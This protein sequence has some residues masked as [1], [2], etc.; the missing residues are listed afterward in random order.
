MIYILGVAHRA[1]SRKPG[2]QKTEAQQFFEFCLRRTVLEVRPA[3]IGEEDNED[4]LADRGEISIAEEIAVELG[5][6]HRFCEPNKKERSA[7]GSKNFMTIALDLAHTESLSNDELECKARA[8]E[9]ARYFPVRE[10]SW[11]ERLK[12]CRS[13][14]CIF[15][16]GD[17]HLRSFGSLLTTEGIPFEVKERGIGVNEEDR[18]YY[19]A[20]EYLEAHPEINQELK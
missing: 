2:G 17:V 1:Q 20:L 6:E 3:F 10:R 7:I 15:V 13:A 4:F 12:D 16:C 19:R 8:V 9:I 14:V 18:P 5:I 11:L